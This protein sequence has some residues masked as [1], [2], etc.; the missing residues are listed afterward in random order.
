MTQPVH[1]PSRRVIRYTYAQFLTD[2]YIIAEQIRHHNREQNWRPDGVFAIARGGLTFATYLAHNLG[3]KVVI[4]LDTYLNSTPKKLLPCAGKVHQY[5]V[6]DDISDSGS[7]LEYHMGALKA[8]AEEDKFE[9]D[10]LC[11]TLWVRSTTTMYPDY[12]ARQIMDESWI[13]F[14]WEGDVSHLTTGYFIEMLS[15]GRQVF[16]PPML[17]GIVPMSDD[18]VE[19][20]ATAKIQL[21]NSPEYATVFAT[22]GE[23]YTVM[24]EFRAKSG[25]YQE[26][27]AIGNPILSQH[28]YNTVKY[29]AYW[30][31]FPAPKP[32]G[33]TR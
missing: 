18:D 15:Y 13:E 29:E 30:R 16:D 28:V 32:K 2:V 11:A 4:D 26:L 21:V 7:T 25:E 27:F 20:A 9:L 33:A 23:A 24:D 10:A 22:A 31:S 17:V 12:F 14:P 5:I 19:H 6:V 3:I 8:K 1:M